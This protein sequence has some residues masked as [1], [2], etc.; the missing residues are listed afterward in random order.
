M[1][2]FSLPYGPQEE[3]VIEYVGELVRSNVADR[4][5]AWY[6]SKGMDSSY[7]F[8]IDDEFVVDATVQGSAARFINHRYAVIG[9]ARGIFPSS[10]RPLVA[11]AEY[12]HHPLARWSRVRN[13]PVIRSP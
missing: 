9:R 1:T 4:R 3:F 5:E 2:P 13:I 12:S 11:R 8:R 6:E 10:A 7:L